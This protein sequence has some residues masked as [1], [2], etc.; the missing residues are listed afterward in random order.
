MQ[1]VRIFAP[2]LTL[3]DAMGDIPL[4]LMIIFDVF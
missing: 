1:G 4:V 2:F 3:R